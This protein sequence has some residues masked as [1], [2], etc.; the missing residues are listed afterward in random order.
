MSVFGDAVPAPEPDE[1]EVHAPADVVVY[2]PGDVVFTVTAKDPAGDQMLRGFRV[3]D[4]GGLVEL[5]PL[6]LAA[7]ATGQGE[8]LEAADEAPGAQG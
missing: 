7:H 3:D 5:S 2:E 1:E 8:A 6:E 4:E